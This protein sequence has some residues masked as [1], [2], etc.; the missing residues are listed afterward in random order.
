MGVSPYFSSIVN[1]QDFT[2]LGSVSYAIP[3]GLLK[4]CSSFTLLP[5]PAKDVALLPPST[6]M[7]ST[8]FSP[9]HF[10]NQATLS[11]IIF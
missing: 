7:F 1:A 6:G 9:L 11:S 4:G 5:N 3:C 10:K 8:V 2:P